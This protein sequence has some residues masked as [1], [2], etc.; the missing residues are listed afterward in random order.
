LLLFASGLTDPELSMA[1]TAHLFAWAG[2]EY[3]AAVNGPQYLI[4]RGTMDPQFRP[5][6]DI[7]CVPSA[8]GLGVALTDEAQTSMTTAAELLEALPV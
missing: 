4:G 6:G 3:P 5:R 2:L 7:M 8:P 1:A